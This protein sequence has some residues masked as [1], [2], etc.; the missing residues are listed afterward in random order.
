L[1]NDTSKFIGPIYYCVTVIIGNRVKKCV[2]VVPLLVALDLDV[3][4]TRALAAASA[5]VARSLPEQQGT[6]KKAAFVRQQPI[7]S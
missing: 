2:D 7:G 5:H 3:A 6:N 1:R 4:E